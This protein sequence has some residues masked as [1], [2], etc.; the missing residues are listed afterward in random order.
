MA[1]QAVAH[2]DCIELLLD[3]GAYGLYN[4]LSGELHWLPEGP[5]WNLV[6][7][8]NS[9]FI[10]ASGPLFF[11]LLHSKVCPHGLSFVPSACMGFVF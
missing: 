8:G 10:V 7:M 5:A 3:D 1:L 9:S 6:Y 4:R 2:R 11:L